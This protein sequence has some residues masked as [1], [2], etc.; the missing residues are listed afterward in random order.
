[1]ILDGAMRALARRGMRKFSMSDVC[2][3]AGISRGTLYRYFRNKEE[4]LEAMAGQVLGSVNS[5]LREAVAA[6]PAPR[7]RAQVVFQ[8]M[9]DYPKRFPYVAMIVQ[10]EPG[11]ALTLFTHAM[12]ELIDSI[13]TALAPALEQAPPAITQV[14][15]GRQLAELFERFILSTYLLPPTDGELHPS[16]LGAAWQRAWATT[17]G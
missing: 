7:D 8:A 10:R 9:L 4:V 17:P 16:R 11:F 2:A 3:E 1:L 6:E 5:V 15:T 12:P 14:M 13:A